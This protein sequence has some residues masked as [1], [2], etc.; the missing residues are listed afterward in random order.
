MT[1][2]NFT[3][4]VEL[5]SIVSTAE[6]VRR[7]LPLVVITFVAVFVGMAVVA[8]Y[9][10]HNLVIGCVAGAVLG[11]VLCLMFFRGLR[12][13]TRQQS[14]RLT[15]TP[16]GLTGTD[17]VLTT[18][19]RWDDVRTVTTPKGASRVGIIGDATLRA[20]PH[21]DPQ[22]LDRYAEQTVD[23]AAFRRGRPVQDSGGAL[24]PGDF[25]ADWRHGTIGA[26]LHHYRPDLADGQSA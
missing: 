21:G 26:W 12:T 8:D 14:Q 4:P 6:R 5:H 10:I 7:A 17:G 20:D 25:E 24:F 16:K 18:T 2:T 13:D 3:A 23:P 1:S 11:V 15:L 22:L 9:L 19:I